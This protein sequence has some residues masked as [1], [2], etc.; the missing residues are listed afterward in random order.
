[1]TYEIKAF[2]WHSNP[3]NCID[4]LNY[5]F[6][7]VTEV[8]DDSFFNDESPSCTFTIEDVKY[9]V[10]FPSDYKG[11]YAQFMLLDE[12]NY[13]ET[14]EFKLLGQFPTISELLN[15]FKNLNVI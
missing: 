6:Q 10:F 14:F 11:D 2:Y 4:I 8:H 1:M 12:T 5:E 13:D 15:Y 7:G 9:K 3:Q